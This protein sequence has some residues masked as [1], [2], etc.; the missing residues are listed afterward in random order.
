MSDS[1]ELVRHEAGEAID[2]AF[3][4]PVA[5]RD[6]LVEA[7][8]GMTAR[9]LF[10]VAAATRLQLIAGSN[11]GPLVSDGYLYDQDGELDRMVWTLTRPA[12]IFAVGGR[13]TFEEGEG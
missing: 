9:D 5:V 13:L 6:E 2:V 1:R 10:A 3:E 8:V 12:R 4:L 7:V 11:G